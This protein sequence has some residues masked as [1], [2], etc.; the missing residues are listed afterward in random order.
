MAS[1]KCKDWLVS[2]LEYTDPTE[3]PTTF[4]FWCGISTIAAALQRHVW[5]DMGF[6]EW[7]PN[8]YIILV[9]PPGIVNKTSTINIGSRMLRELKTIHEGP[10]VLTWQALVQ[11]MA[12]ASEMFECNGEFHTQCA[13]HIAAG[14]LGNLLDPSNR[15]LLD[16]LTAL[17][18]GQREPFRKITKT[19]GSD[20]IINPCLNLIAGT[21]PAWISTH[22]PEHFIGGG[23]ASRCIFLFANQKRRLEAYPKQHYTA[24]HSALY[25]A[26]VHDLELIN[27]L[28]GEYTLTPEAM[29][30]GEAWYESHYKTHSRTM[31]TSRFGGY[32]ARKQTH[33]HKLAMVLAAASSDGLRIT[34]E[35]LQKAERIITATEAALSQV[36]AGIGE[37]PE[38]RHLSEIVRIVHTH[39][40]IPYQRLYAYMSRVVLAADFDKLV[41]SAQKAGLVSVA[42]A[43][44]E[45]IVVAG[46][47]PQQAHEDIS[48]AEG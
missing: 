31:A 47:T 27:T 14:E 45:L 36:F 25:D 9:A 33:I 4:H 18:D 37:T 22:V 19:Q 34:A 24:Q 28:K 1:R 15:D 23:L 38:G 39:G 41:L 20:T 26:L 8:F 3:A 40:R 43:G 5:I 13:L 6:F 7:V 11:T 44:D 42:K 46:R 16:V 32:L 35:H 2:Y 30:W 29:A 12:T 21:T 10:N 48:A 17:W